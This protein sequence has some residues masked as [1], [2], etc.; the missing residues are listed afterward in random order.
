MEGFLSVQNQNCAKAASCHTV[1]PRPKISQKSLH[2]QAKEN[3]RCT[4]PCILI[5]EFKCEVDFATLPPLKFDLSLN[6]KRKLSNNV[7]V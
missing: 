5:N 7:K 1:A 6:V 3:S 4:D 2:K